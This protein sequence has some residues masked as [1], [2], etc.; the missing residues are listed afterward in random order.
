MIRRLSLLWRFVALP[1]APLSPIFLVVPPYQSCV[2]VEDILRKFILIMY[3]GGYQMNGKPLPPAKGH[4]IRL[5]APGIYGCR[6]VKWLDRITVQPTESRN[7][8]QQRDYKILPPE[9]VDSATAAPHWNSTPAMNDMAIN[10][11]IAIPQSGDTV[12][13]VPS[14]SPSSTSSST[15]SSAS[16]PT[17]SSPSF[18]SSSSFST[19]TS[20]PYAGTIEAKG[21]AVPQGDQGPVIRVEVSIDEGETWTDAELLKSPPLL[22]LDKTATATETG[23]E[24]GPGPGPVKWSWTL[25]RASIPIEHGTTQVSIFSRATDSGGNTQPAVSPWNLRGVGYNGYGRAVGVKILC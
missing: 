17:S 9:A 22:P 24:T 5:I 23:A 12:A 18:S 4:P 7:F 8:Y 2:E 11:I 25:W 10:S 16:S 13:L 14:P 20:S 1:L 15:S 19:S 21:Y 6:S 3:E